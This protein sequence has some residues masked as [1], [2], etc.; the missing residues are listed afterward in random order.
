MPCARA[1]RGSRKAATPLLT[2]STPVIAVQP[3]A[4]ARSTSQ[5]PRVA[6]PVRTE[7]GVSTGCGCPADSQILAT[8]QA[9]IPPRLPM[10]R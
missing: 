5:M 2:A 7:G 10:N 1:T 3:L 4:N 8:P 9:S 6:L